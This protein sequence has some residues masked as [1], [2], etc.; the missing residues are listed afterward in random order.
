MRNASISV[1]HNAI[2]DVRFRRGRQKMIFFISETT[3]AS[4]FNI[5]HNTAPA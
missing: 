4:N 1:S 5:S 3:T 2:V